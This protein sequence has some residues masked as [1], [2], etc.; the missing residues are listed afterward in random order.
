MGGITLQRSVFDEHNSHNVTDTINRI[1]GSVSKCRNSWLSSPMHRPT[2]MVS[3]VVPA[4]ADHVGKRSMDSAEKRRRAT[5][6]KFRN[7]NLPILVDSTGQSAKDG[8]V[9]M[10]HNARL[11]SSCSTI[12]SVRPF[13]SPLWVA[14]RSVL[15]TAQPLSTLGIG[16]Y[17]KP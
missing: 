3:N 5:N 16:I 1:H 14:R 4:G 12:V 13:S 15:V 7:V 17:R 11:G 10:T 9:S 6:C 8:V 2:A